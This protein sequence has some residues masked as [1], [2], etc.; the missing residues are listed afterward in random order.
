MAIEVEAK[1]RADGPRP[2]DELAR[3]AT[4][5]DAGLG[6][7]TSVH[8]VDRYLDT[9]DGRIGAARWACRL[10]SRAGTVTVSLKGPAA[11]ASG[12]WLHH[13]PEVEGPATASLDPA[14]WPQSEARAT[15]DRLRAGG[16][17]VERFRLDQ[18]RVERQVVLDGAVFGTLSLDHAVVRR[19]DRR[20]GDLWVVELEVGGDDD[21]AGGPAL[22]RLADALARWPGLHPDPTTK[23]E[24]AVELLER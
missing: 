20:A 13:R 21:G 19:G 12:S 18:R 2:L 8:E 6:A 23:L 24:H 5:G 16:S 17:L 14:D 11:A 9:A 1:F 15:V 4:L 3:A 22:A 7:A 10:R